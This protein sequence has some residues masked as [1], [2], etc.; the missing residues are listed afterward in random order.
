MRFLFHIA[1]D[2]SKY[3]GWQF[4]TNAYTVQEAL[5]QKLE[6]IFKRKIT[7]FG[8][9]RTDRGVHA[10][11]YF[12]HIEL[13]KAP[14]FDFEFI[15]R[16][17]LPASI[18]LFE[19]IPFEDSFHSRYHAVKRTYDYFLHTKP[20]PFLDAYST[21]HGYEALDF[22]LMREAAGLIK[23]YK[24]FRT[25]CLQPDAHNHTLC[26]ISKSQLFIDEELGRIRFSITGN[27]FLKGMNRVLIG[28][29]VKVGRKQ[30]TVNE[31]EDYL[32]T[33]RDLSDLK[34]APPNGLYLSEVEYPNLK[35]PNKS[36]LF[37]LLKSG[38]I[39]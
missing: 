11:Q 17:H 5:E 31:F 10:S 36:Q 16:K 39:D 20:D 22:Q 33:P 14:D 7:V 1:Y 9:G 38:L 18:S 37:G 30:I 34:T 8:C 27:R 26:E 3:S 25:F 21:F 15:F 32:K 29:L 4:Q 35:R 19:I 28:G 24:D 13:D 12:F 6:K 2:G 23:H